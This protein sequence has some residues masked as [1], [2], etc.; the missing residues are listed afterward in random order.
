MTIH[1]VMDD[2]PPRL[3]AAHQRVQSTQ[4]A[5][6]LALRHRWELVTTAVD[7][8]MSQ[9][10]VARIM[11]VTQ[12]AVAKILARTFYDDDMPAAAA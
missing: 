6:A 8:G 12:P 4:E 1:T 3:L 9:S 10:E 5:H 2:M 11:G 7:N